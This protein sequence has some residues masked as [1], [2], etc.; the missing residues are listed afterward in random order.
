M[1][2]LYDVFLAVADTVLCL[3]VFFPLAVLHWRGTWDLLDVYLVPSNLLYSSWASIIIGGSG[4]FFG[5]L[6][7]HPLG[8]WAYRG[9]RVRYVL[10]SRIY[11]YVFSW[12]VLCYWRGLWNLMDLYMGEG[13]LNAVTWYILGVALSALFRTL[14]TNAGLPVQIQIDTDPDMIC[15]PDTRFKTTVCRC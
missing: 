14:R 9:S 11:L 1:C 12:T 15:E 3:F 5:Y 8:R 13:L 4:C 2:R 6:L 7:Q 10:V